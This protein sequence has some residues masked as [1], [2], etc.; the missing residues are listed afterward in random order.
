MRRVR[1]PENVAAADRR[2]LSSGRVS[3]QGWLPDALATGTALRELVAGEEL[4]RRGDPA[5]AIFEVESGR[6]RLVRR[7]VDDH[8]VIL[9]TASAGELFAEAALFAEAYHRDAVAAAPSSVRVYPKAMLLSTMRAEPAV[10]EAFTATLAR[11]LQALRARLELRNIRSAHERLLQYLVLAAG[12]DG[13]TVRL[14]SPLQD[15]AGD[16][17]LSREALYRTLAKLE[18]DGVLTRTSNALVLGK[19][20]IA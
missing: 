16:L 9:H 10:L 4:F 15:I 2:K 14:A 18:A 19:F 20:A 17:G 3:R 6:L 13:R 1:R 5:A 7:T 12:P 11:Q 8:L